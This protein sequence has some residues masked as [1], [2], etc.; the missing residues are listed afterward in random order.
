MNNYDSTNETKKHIGKV[1]QRLMDI[2]IN[3]TDR[4]VD[5]DA[6][7]LKQPEKEA[8][9]SLGPAEEM[10]KLTYGSPEYRANLARIKPA[11]N[12]HYSKNDHHPEHYKLWKCPL[13]KVVYR[14]ADLANDKR[15]PHFCPKCVPEGSMYEAVLEPHVSVNGMSLMA[16]LEMLADWKAAGER[17]ANGNLADS[18]SKNQERFHIEPQLQAVLENTAKELGWL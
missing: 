17:H 16:L 14:E 7:K 5:H 12:H 2:H 15:D 11:I 18:L 1:Q 6:S 8:F 9:D 3:L 13:C 4:S 10:A